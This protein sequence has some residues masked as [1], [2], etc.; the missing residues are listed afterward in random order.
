MIRTKL[1]FKKYLAADRERLGN[2]SFS[3]LHYFFYSEQYFLYKYLSVLRKLEYLSNK[4]RGIFENLEYYFCLRKYKKQI[5]LTQINIPINVIGPGLQIHHLGQII[6]N[7]N[8][9]IGSNC[10]L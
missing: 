4:N 10:S 2:M 6:I 7:A 3:V 9:R 5:F 8:A 1:D